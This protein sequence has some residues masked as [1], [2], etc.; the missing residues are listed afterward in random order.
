MRAALS[1]GGVAR[2]VEEADAYTGKLGQA[3]DGGAVALARG[4]EPVGVM[5]ERAVMRQHA[6]LRSAPRRAPQV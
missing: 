1:T 4:R 3:R 6:R 2:G 5:L